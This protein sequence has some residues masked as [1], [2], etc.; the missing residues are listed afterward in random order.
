MNKL[1]LSAICI[2]FIATGCLQ[3][4]GNKEKNNLSDSLNYT[5]QITTKTETDS[6][7]K[8]SSALSNASISYPVVS[9]SALAD[10]INKV[11]QT[12]IF[13]NYSTAQMA[14]DSFV[15][16]AIKQKKENRGASFHGWFYNGNAHIVHNTG[17]LLTLRIDYSEYSGGA[18]PNSN[19]LYF[20]FTG[21]GKQLSLEDLIIPGQYPAFRKLNEQSLRQA[22]Q[23]PANESW[24]QAGF[25]LDSNELPLPQFF[26]LTQQ[27]VLMSY[28]PYE[29][30][31]YVMGNIS[32]V[33]PYTELNGIIDKN[34]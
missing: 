7:V 26:A 32:Y 2:L 10:S 3:L 4:S 31:P 8:D 20:N 27:G 17:K 16:N 29:I 6:T 23:I 1:F 33:I 25:L 22:K 9:G 21:D 18:H 14:V 15:N 30:A 12:S 13:N 5:Y 19:I 34:F 11:L 24:E 28:N